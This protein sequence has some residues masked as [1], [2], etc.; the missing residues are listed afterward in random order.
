MSHLPLLL[1][2]SNMHVIM[3]I[4]AVMAKIY[5]I[6]TYSYTLLE[7]KNIESKF[8]IETNLLLY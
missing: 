7:H 3:F 6:H 1:Q 5:I 2:I 8:Q 4:R